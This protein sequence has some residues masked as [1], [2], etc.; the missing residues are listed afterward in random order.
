MNIV[1]LNKARL[2]AQY[3]TFGSPAVIGGVSCLVCASSHRG[4]S[5]LQEGGL[6]VDYD[7]TVRCQIA[8]FAN[9]IAPGSR[10]TIEGT[11]YRIENVMKQT[12]SGEYVLSLSQQR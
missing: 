11:T 12:I 5:S 8:D 1:A 6:A 10:A 4:D 9:G 3:K 7:R 2:Q